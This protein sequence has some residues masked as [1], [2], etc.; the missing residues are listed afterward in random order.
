MANLNVGQDVAN[1]RE[2]RDMDFNEVA[3]SY[4]LQQA[5]IM[6][7]YSSLIN[8]NPFASGEI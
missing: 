5:T 4:T 3:K 1:K 2:I 6:R 7:R 8:I